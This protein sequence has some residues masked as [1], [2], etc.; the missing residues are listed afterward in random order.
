MLA[1]TWTTAGR[2]LN[3]LF[4]P[5]VWAG[6]AA[7][8]T[9][10]YTGG[11]T[12]LTL[13]AAV[14]P[15]FGLRHARDGA[16]GFVRSV[17]HEVFWM[18]AMG[19]PL[20]GL[21]HIAVGSFLS[22]QAYYGSTF[23]DGTGAVVG[24]GLL[25]NLGGLMTGLTLAGILAARIV[26]ELRALLPHPGDDAT[27]AIPE[28]QASRPASFGEGVNRASPSR[29]HANPYSASTMTV[30]AP[31]AAHAAPRA[32]SRSPVQ[33]RAPRI[34]IHSARLAAPRIAAA[35]VACTLLSQW[36]VAVGTLVGWQASHSMMGL[37]TDVFFLMMGKMMWLRDVVG[38][39]IKGVLYGGLPGAICCYEGLR[40]E[41]P[42]SAGGVTAS[43][44]PSF[45]T[46][47]PLTAAVFRATLLSFVAI[48]VVNASWFI[49]VY[50][51]VPFYGPTLLPPGGS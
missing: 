8:A 23:V 16:P 34:R 13:E 47:P 42:P 41:E 2:P 10:A 39:L 38:L 17:I 44:N 32:T 36:G 35:A 21:V 6:R 28:G 12:L 40:H 46:A 27:G 14:S 11:L 50:H 20:V 33:E 43:L 3:S 26:P 51:A 48:L 22:L 1:M 29:E 25:R 45:G 5:V 24:V 7:L 31:S 15:I 19:L 49:L 9:V 37:S 30:T 18:L 4:A